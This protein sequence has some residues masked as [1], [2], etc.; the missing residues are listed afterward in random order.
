MSRRVCGCGSRAFPPGHLFTLRRSRSR[1]YSLLRTIEWG[2]PFGVYVLRDRIDQRGERQRERDDSGPDRPEVAAAF[3]P[4]AG[5]DG[6]EV[7]EVDAVDHLA[8]AWREE[9]LARPVLK[10]L[11]AVS[12]VEVVVQATEDAVRLDAEL[13]RDGLDVQRDEDLCLTLVKASVLV[14]MQDVMVLRSRKSVGGRFAHR[15][16]RSRI[17]PRLAAAFTAPGSSM[18]SGTRASLVPKPAGIGPNP[19]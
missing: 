16:P 15:R 6:L 1:R 2:A 8:G 4:E 3:E 5:K 17:S 12:A 19:A 14:E 11:L 9:R 18:G 10:G 7:G 13:L